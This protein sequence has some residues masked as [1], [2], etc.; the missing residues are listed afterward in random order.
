MAAMFEFKD[1]QMAAKNVAFKSDDMLKTFEEQIQKLENAI[2]NKKITAFNS[3]VKDIQEFLKGVKYQKSVKEFTSKLSSLDMTVKSTRG[4][5]F[6]AIKLDSDMAVDGEKIGERKMSGSSERG[7]HEFQRAPERKNLQRLTPDSCKQPSDVEYCCQEV[8]K[9]YDKLKIACDK[10]QKTDES[11]LLQQG[12]EEAKDQKKHLQTIIE[13]ADKQVNKLVDLLDMSRGTS[14]VKEIKQEKH[15][16]IVTD[17]KEQESKAKLTAIT[18]SLDKLKKQIED[19]SYDVTVFQKLKVKDETHDDM[20]K[21]K[22]CLTDICMKLKNR[23]DKEKRQTTEKEKIRNDWEKQCQLIKKILLKLKTDS[24]DNG[25][26]KEEPT[27][28]TSALKELETKILENKKSLKEFNEM[29]EHFISEINLLKEEITRFDDETEVTIK[30]NATKSNILQEI[31]N[32]RKA[33]NA[34]KKEIANDEKNSKSKSTKLRKHVNSLWKIAFNTD[35]DVANAGGDDGKTHDALQMLNMIVPELEKFEK[36]SFE[37]EDASEKIHIDVIG[38]PPFLKDT[39]EL[40]TPIGVLINVLKTLKSCHAETSLFVVKFSELESAMSIERSNKTISEKC[41][42]MTK[43]A[44]RWKTENHDMNDILGKC[45]KL[46]PM[47]YS[48]LIS[49][50]YWFSE[51]HIKMETIEKRYPEWLHNVAYAISNIRGCIKENKD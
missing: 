13:A 19:C 23:N 40:K 30:G 34:K 8:Q 26:Q 17:K 5:K 32:V 3:A 50:P 2:I 7:H 51:P 29:Q 6:S 21:C 45:L 47:A 49:E 14:K 42:L 33:L 46:L 39:E 16:Q 1:L 12:K 36:I 24:D 25:N 11:P 20:N 27:D 48:G 4:N 37:V 38:A 18:D 41:K 43:D 9:L 10:H 44:L 35:M 22:A 31:R 15:I 28:T